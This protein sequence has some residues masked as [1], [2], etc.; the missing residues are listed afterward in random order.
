M[1]LLTTI[2]GVAVITTALAAPAAASPAGGSGTL[3]EPYASVDWVWGWGTSGRVY[4]TYRCPSDAYTDINL[5]LENKETGEIV[6]PAPARTPCNGGLQS[7]TVDYRAQAMQSGQS[8]TVTVTAAGA[9]ATT[10]KTMI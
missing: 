10:T 9:T 6:V 7:T 1:K 5:R 3:P 2:A 4:V 8:V